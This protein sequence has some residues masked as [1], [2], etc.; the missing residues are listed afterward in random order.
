MP[1]TK[2]LVVDDDRAITSVV[3]RMLERIGLY[4]V[5]EENL[6]DNALRA[7]QEFLPNIVL[8][9]WQMPI[10]DGAEVAIQILAEPDFSRVPIVFITAF[11][12][13]ARKFGYPCLEKP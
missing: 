7:A 2:V 8:L 6:A 5:R 3:K 12:Q 13:R 1:K 4:E 9:D 10:M 11:G